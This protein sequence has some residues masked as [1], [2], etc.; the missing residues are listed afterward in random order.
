MKAGK[1]FELL[2]KNVLGEVSLATPAIANGR[3][4][5]RTREALYCIGSAK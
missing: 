4:F 1:E 3:L 5:L 2:G